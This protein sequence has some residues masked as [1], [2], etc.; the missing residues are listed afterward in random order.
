MFFGGDD[1]F[2]S[3]F[4]GGG[5]GGGGFGGFGLLRMFYFGGYL[6][7]EEMDVDD[8]GYGYFGGG[9]MGGG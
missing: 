4:S 5:G 2:V 1:L 8:E 3:F 7:Q 6:G 9:Y